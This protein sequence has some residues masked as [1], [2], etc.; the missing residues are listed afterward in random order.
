MSAVLKPGRAA[1]PAQPAAPRARPVLLRPVAK[2]V[3]FA[4][5]LLPFAW[6]LYGA[7]ANTLGAN[8]AEA[9]LRATGDWTLRFLC[10][11]LAVTPL[12]QWTGQPAL[13]RFRRMLGLFAFF[14]ATLHFFAYAWFDMGLDLDAITRDILAQMDFTPSIGAQLQ[15]MDASLFADMTMGLRESMLEVPLS[16][17]IEFDPR[18]Q[19]LFINFEGMKVDSEADVAAI[20]Q[21]VIQRVAPLGRRVPVVVNYDHF[22]IR[23]ELMDSY[24]AMVQRLSDRYYDKVT[25]YAASGF[26]KARLEK[27]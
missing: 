23:P 20:E 12:R 26:V 3:L 5:C 10:I 19:V 7:I 27:S 22:S 25:R 13:A 16:E 14:Y 6:L 18:A 21:E 1:A 9:L 11:T 2:P 4:L 24:G 15:L 8:P 17:R